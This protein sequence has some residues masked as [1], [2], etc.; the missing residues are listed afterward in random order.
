MS[1]AAFVL[2]DGIVG[3]TEA[4]TTRK[5]PSPC[6][7]QIG[8]DNSQRILAHAACADRVIHGRSVLPGVIQQFVV[9]RD[10][11]AGQG[12]GPAIGRQRAGAQQT[13][14]PSETVDDGAL[15]GRR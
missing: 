14:A 8:A 10:I 1:V 11:R 2:A 7:F 9:G 4:S 5:P 6:T 3:M 15:I 12:L 13:P